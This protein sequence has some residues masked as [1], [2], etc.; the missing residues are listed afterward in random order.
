M[1]DLTLFVGLD[2]HKKT[3]SVALVDAAAKADVRFY[4]TIANEP[5]AL[6]SLCR[7]LSKDGRRLH[8]CYEAGP[9]GYGVQRHLTRLGLR[10]GG[11]VADPAQGLRQGEDRPARRDA[12]ADAARR[13]VDGGLGAG[14]GTRGDAG[15]GA[16]AGAGD[17]GSWIQLASATFDLK[18]AISSAMV[19]AGVFHPSVLRG[20]PFMSRA[21]S[22]SQ[23]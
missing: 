17:A 22:L 4:G 12:G 23:V 18:A 2:V 3:I 7:R 15:P 16:V 10:R 9:C 21:T 14:R 8:F 11:A 5:D 19:S 20:R 6:R 13:A 1:T